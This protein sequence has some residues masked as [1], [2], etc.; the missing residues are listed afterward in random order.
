MEMF[1]DVKQ[2]MTQG[3]RKGQIG[4]VY[5]FIAAVIAIGILLVVGTVM[6][7]QLRVINIANLGN[8]SNATLMIDNIFAL[9]NTTEGVVV[10]VVVIGL[11]ALALAYLLGAFGG[12][13]RGEQ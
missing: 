12:Q 8:N 7:G 5:A 6:L 4:G 11:L 1:E 10:L 2:F 3:K 9:L 13:R